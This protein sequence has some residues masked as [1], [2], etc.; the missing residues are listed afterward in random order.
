MKKFKKILEKLKK[1]NLEELKVFLRYY[2]SKL[3]KVENHCRDLVDKESDLSYIT[4]ILGSGLT[5]INNTT[6]FPKM[7]EEVYQKAKSVL[8]YI[9]NVPN[10][11]YSEDE[12]MFVLGYTSLYHE[13][14][15]LEEI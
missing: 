1:M 7:S 8:G 9:K 10:H 15:K 14:A 13:R 2:S 5:V 4:S 11:H 6:H 12:I 3:S